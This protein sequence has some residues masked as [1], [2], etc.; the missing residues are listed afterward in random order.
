MTAGQLFSALTQKQFASQRGLKMTLVGVEQARFNMIE[1]QI[2]TWEVL[3]QS[4]LDLFFQ[5]RREEFVPPVYR[6]LAFADLEIPL[7]PGQKMWPPKLEARVIQ[8]LKLAP[9]ER[10]L[11]VGTGS[12]YFTTLLARK[13]AHV[14]SVEIDSAL[15]ARAKETLARH[16]VNNVTL[17]CGDAARGWSEGAPYDVIVLTGSTPVL[18]ESVL[19]MLKVGG[20]LFAVVGDLPVMEGRIVQRTSEQYYSSR[21]VFETVLDPLLNAAQ[22]ERFVF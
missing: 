2:R 15:H 22:P 17:A 8:E 20:R 11:E 4:V 6:G 12:G 3:D 19:Q 14:T 10:A 1:Q 18:P 7:G 21:D 13:L 16:R 5:V 9:T